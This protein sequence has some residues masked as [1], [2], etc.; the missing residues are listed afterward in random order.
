MSGK[1]C[2]QGMTD[3]CEY[4]GMNH[5]DGNEPPLREW[6]M[7]MAKIKKIKE[8]VRLVRWQGILMRVFFR[9]QEQRCMTAVEIKRLAPTIVGEGIVAS[10]RLDVAAPRVEGG[11]PM[12]RSMRHS[13]ARRSEVYRPLALG[14]SW[15]L[16]LRWMTTSRLSLMRRGTVSRSS[17]VHV[18][19]WAATTPKRVRTAPGRLAS[20]ETYNIS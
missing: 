5:G 8:V 14:S 17:A 10:C 15:R 1:T 7:V 18:A 4:C 12:H 16:Q 3:V 11:P 6:K 2:A 9:L 13:D 20:P 19:R